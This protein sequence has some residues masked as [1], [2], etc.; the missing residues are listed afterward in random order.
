MAIKSTVISPSLL[1]NTPVKRSKEC[2]ERFRFGLGEWTKSSASDEAPRK[3][4][5]L[6]L[7]QRFKAEKGKENR[8]QFMSEAREATLGKKFVPKNTATSTII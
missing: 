8:W 3:K 4:L 5:K 7:G 2:H 6:S 1:S